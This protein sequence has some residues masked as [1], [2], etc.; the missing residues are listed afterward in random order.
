MPP[1]RS[2]CRTIAWLLVL[3]GCAG[4]QDETAPASAAPSVSAVPMTPAAPLALS[5]ETPP[6]RVWIFN[7]TPGDDEHHAFYE[8]NLARLRKAFAER[9]GLPAGHLTILYGP[10]DAG[11]DG[12][13]TRE[14][15]LGELGKAAEST[16][17]PGA[18]PVWL[19]FQGHANQI[20]GGC[21]FNLPG[22]D[23]S[24]RDIGEALKS[25]TPN[26]RIVT[27]ATTTC[28]SAFIRP[29]AAPGRI[30]LA[31]TIPAD[32]ENET[33]F[34][35]ALAAALESADTDSNRDGVVS[36]TELFLAC[37]AG[38]QKIY[39][40]GGFMIKEHAQLDGDGDGRATQRP[41]PKDAEAAAQVVLRMAKKEKQFE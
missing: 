1:K 21:N 35:E 41:S 31:S 8:K 39:A 29:L 7:G 19:I 18:G 10:K 36:V 15:L 40:A 4:A 28:S 25:A 27:L 26:V 37:H 34:P 11:Y 2:I 32:P 3:G 12:P 33:E 24:A 13:C 23:V 16:R 17:Q 20:P 5:K 9:F 6:P 30:T 38:V 14:A 22:P